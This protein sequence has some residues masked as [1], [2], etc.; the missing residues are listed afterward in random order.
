MKGKHLDRRQVLAAAAAGLAT[1]LS[2]AI[3]QSA[4]QEPAD[5]APNTFAPSGVALGPAVP[6]SFD[7]LT[8]RAKENSGSPWE[9]TPV[10]APDV[11]ERID[12]DAFQTIRYR[13]EMSLMLNHGR[14]LP[15]QLFH[16]GKF[17][18]DPVKIHLV[19]GDKTQEV[20]YLSLI[21][22]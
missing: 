2:G 6:F 16:L 13:T 14:T 7:L 19:Q 18:R 3:S 9:P 20:L 17:S 15:V 12:Y 10:V 4:A 11:L 8:E 21:H 1:S 5:G 22:I